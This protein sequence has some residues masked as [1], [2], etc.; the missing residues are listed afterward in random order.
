MSAKPGKAFAMVAA[1]CLA[2]LFSQGSAG[3]RAGDDDPQLYTAYNI[4]YEQ[5]TRIW[6]TNY[7]KG[8]LLPAGTAIT[9]VKSSK[10]AITF[11]EVETDVTYT[12]VFVRKHHPGKG[13][14]D[15]YERFVTDKNFEE[16]TAG[17]SKSEVD[18]IKAGEVVNGMSKEAVLV[19]FGYPPE[20]A[21]PK[22]SSNRWQYWRHRFASRVVNFSEGKVAS[23]E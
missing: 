7:Q 9:R 20:V 1:L 12:L 15:I 18:A 6:S 17:F 10:K 19:A 8:T 5:P 11:T 22:T 16:L 13:V 23:M 21:T 3:V 14:P 4:W 2:V